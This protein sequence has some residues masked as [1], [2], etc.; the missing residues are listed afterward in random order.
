MGVWIGCGSA[1]SVVVLPP[2]CIVIHTPK[3]RGALR[4]VS[5][6]IQPNLLHVFATALL[7]TYELKTRIT[8]VL[9]RLSLINLTRT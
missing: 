4:R 8:Y 2:L 7:E 1:K 9:T 6:N 5:P 3:S